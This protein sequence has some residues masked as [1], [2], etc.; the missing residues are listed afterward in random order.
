[1]EAN[2]PIKGLPQFLKILG[3][4]LVLGASLWNEK[5]PLTKKQRKNLTATETLA[6]S[7]MREKNNGRFMQQ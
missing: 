6:K 7:L 1:M 5:A 4:K 2:V 3:D